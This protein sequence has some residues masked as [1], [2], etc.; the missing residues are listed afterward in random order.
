MSPQRPSSTTVR[1]GDVARAAGVSVGTVSKALNGT[2][3]LREETRRH[4]RET[5]ERLGFVADARARGLVA[6]RT[7]TVGFL[8][9]DSFGRFML[10]ILM[11]AEDALSVGQIAVI[12]A[13][14]RDD[15][16]REQHL[17]RSLRSRRVDG[18]I[19]TGRTTDARDPLDVDIPVVHAFAPSNDDSAPA[20]LTDE[21]G[22]ARL[23]VEHLLAIGRR[24]ILHVTGPERHRSS[25]VRA[26]EVRRVAG[27]ALV[28]EPMFGAW[29][30]EWG[31]R[32]IDLALAS[33]LEFDAVCAGSDQIARGVLD[34]LRERGL[35]VPADV[36][37]TGVDNWDVMALAARPALTTADLCLAEI[38]RRS[39]EMLLDLVEGRELSEQRV[40]V[41]PRLEVRG[42]TV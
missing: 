42:S 21:A 14:T 30:E 10:P 8:T 13:D 38:G 23:V 40:V 31:L 17:L 37:V 18:L 41:P 24:R 4:V 34:R 19:V 2:G 29:S 27:E 20:V 15:H 26:E 5:A 28:G 33:G 36:A 9:T 22:A 35:S 3:S 12:L 25:R 16:A 39:G 6:G 11:G 7:Y 1:I 32:A